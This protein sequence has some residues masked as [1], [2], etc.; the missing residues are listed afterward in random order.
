MFV[1]AI[2]NEEHIKNNNNTFPNEAHCTITQK[3]KTKN[4]GAE[5]RVLLKN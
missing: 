5:E 4:S 3:S 1:L 2:F